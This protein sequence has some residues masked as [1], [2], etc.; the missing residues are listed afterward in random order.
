[1]KRKI[2]ISIALLSCFLLVMAVTDGLTGKWK[3][4]LRTTDGRILPVAY[5]FKAEGDKLTGT[6]TSPEGVADILDGKII[7]NTFSFKTIGSEGDT[8]HTTGKIYV[9]SC[10]IDIDFGDLKVHLKVMRDTTR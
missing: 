1:M 4:T 7:G 8:Y 2:L 10:G 5:N 9:D 6:T 3:G